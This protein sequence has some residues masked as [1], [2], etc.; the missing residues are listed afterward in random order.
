MPEWIL[1]MYCHRHRANNGNLSKF[2]CSKISK[3]Q[4]HIGKR[5][6]R[7]SVNSGCRRISAKACG[8]VDF[9]LPSGR[10]STLRQF[11]FPLEQTHFV[12]LPNLMLYSKPLLSTWWIVVT[13]RLPCISE[14]TGGKDGHLWHLVFSYFSVV[15]R[16]KSNPSA[17]LFL[18]RCLDWK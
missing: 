5:N 7:S 8:A 16:A 4:G 14:R 17:H 10:C 2:R 1:C 9:H 12:E 15:P 18:D 3:V 11:F 6:V 13:V